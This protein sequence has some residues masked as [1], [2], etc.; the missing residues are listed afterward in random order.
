[1]TLD[2]TVTHRLQTFFETR[3][4]Q[5]AVI[6]VVVFNAALLGAETSKNLVG[7]YGPLLHFLND[8]CLSLFVVELVLKLF[9]YRLRFFAS[10]WNLLDFAIV[11]VSLMPA[12][13]EFSICAPYAFSACCALFQPPPAC[14]VWSKALSQPYQGWDLFSC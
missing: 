14:A 10:G 2:M 12:G 4:F 11:A 8:V 7:T 6:A 5:N 9:A 13:Q 1:M 3:G